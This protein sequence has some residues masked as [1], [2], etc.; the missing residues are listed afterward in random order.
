MNRLHFKGCAGSYVACR[1]RDLR[2]ILPIVRREDPDAFYITEQACD[3]S[4]I[5][6]PFSSPITG[7]RSPFSG[8]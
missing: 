3:V 5:L 8:K 4:K 6:R 1:R 7:W 2:W